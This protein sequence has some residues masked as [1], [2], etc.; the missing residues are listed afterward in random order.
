MSNIAK[1]LDTIIIPEPSSNPYAFH[2]SVICSQT[3]EVVNKIPGETDELFASQPILFLSG[4]GTTSS[5]GKMT[6][7]LRDYTPT[8]D[9]CLS[10]D[11]F[12][13]VVFNDPYIIFS[14]TARSMSPVVLTWTHM[15]FRNDF[16]AGDNA[17]HLVSGELLDPMP[18]HYYYFD[19]TVFS[20]N[21]NK[22]PL[23]DITFSWSCIS[24]AVGWW[25]EV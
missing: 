4:L 11:N 9:W 18:R 25:Y 17:Y 2:W 6:I 23:R 15:A 1:P 3:I 8:H 14:A 10:A 13:R 12:E 5:D 19:I 16:S 22:N 20:W 24:N 7:Q 21:L